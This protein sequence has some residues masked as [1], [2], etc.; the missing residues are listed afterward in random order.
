MLYLYK[1]DIYKYINVNIW[2][3]ES[4]FVFYINYYT[5]N[6]F[7]YVLYYLKVVEMYNFDDWY[8]FI[9][10]E[11]NSIFIKKDLKIIKNFKIN[12]EY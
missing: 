6:V 8:Y 11:I 10:F 12:E 9:F 3:N 7:Y 2:W 5:T 1:K 4:V